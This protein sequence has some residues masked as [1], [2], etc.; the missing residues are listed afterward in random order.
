MPQT[1]RVG[2]I[3]CGWPGEAHAKGYAAAGGFKL[4]AVADLIPQRRQKLS[5]QFGIERQYTDAKELLADKELDVISVCL[6]TAQHAPIAIAAL[7]SGRHVLLEK[8]PA[9]NAK[10]ARQIEAA[11]AKAKKVLLYGLQRR[12]GPAEQAARQAIVRGYAGGVYHV[13]AQWLRTRGIPIGT[14]WFV[15]KAQSGGGAM[16]DIGVHML[17]LAWYL[18]GQPGPISAFAVCHHKF[19]HLA[20]RNLKMDVEDSAYALI[21]FEG[22]KS[23]ELAASWALNQ[24]PQQQGTLCRVYGDKAAIDVYTPD[25]AM[26]HRDFDQKGQSQVTAL[27]PPKISG[28]AAMA[29]HFRQCILGKAK[30]LAGPVEGVALMQ[31]IDAIYKSAQTG[32]SVKIH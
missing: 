2:I 7:R 1:L 27:P 14:G 23:L 20:P 10:Q 28:H 15:Q 16:I 26:L 29:R 6:P 17:D 31:M 5:S 21:R 3:G 8:P 24:P 13:R 19:A 4:V 9:L 22:G 18:L 11:A 30:P 12:F 32:K 25:G